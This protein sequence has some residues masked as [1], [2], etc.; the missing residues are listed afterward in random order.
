MIE[1]TRL[2]GEEVDDGLGR[3]REFSESP[4]P[5]PSMMRCSDMSGDADDQDV[6]QLMINMST[7]SA[8]EVSLVPSPDVSKVRVQIGK[9]ASS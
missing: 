8:P 7:I 9:L 1:V 2:E 3:E 5:S 4:Q 6:S